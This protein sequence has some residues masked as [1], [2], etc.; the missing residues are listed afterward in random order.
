MGRKKNHPYLFLRGSRWWVRV[1][2]P[3][4]LR[5][6]YTSPHVERS[7]GTDSLKDAE[8]ER[9]LR[10][11][12]IKREFRDKLRAATGAMPSDVR[13]ALGLRDDIRKLHRSDDADDQRNLEALE[14]VVTDRAYDIAEKGGTERAK[15]FATIAL[16]TK[17]KTLQE[18]FAEWIGVEG[19]QG[20]TCAKYRR[21]F[22]EVLGHFGLPDALPSFVTAERVRGYVEYV[23]TKAVT[24]KGAPLDPATKR[25]R[26]NAMS[27]FWRWMESV[28]LAPAG[29]AAFWRGHVIAGARAKARQV[30]KERPYKDAEIIALCEGP[31][32]RPNATYSKR[33]MIEL[34]AL[35]LLTGARLEE[36]C[37]RTLGDIEAVKGAGY[38]LHIRDAKTPSGNRSLPIRHAIAVAVIKRRIGKRSDPNAYLFAELVPGGPD[39]K[40]SWQVQKSLGDY[41]RELG[42]PEGVNFHST[43]RSFATRME[44]LGVEERWAERYFGHK[45]KSLIGSIYSKPQVLDDVAKAIKYPAPIERA[46]RAALGL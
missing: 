44:E 25:A 2:V 3:A 6:F 20:G 34:T 28:D 21:A 4:K 42:L 1:K 12:Q 46:L 27:G 24:P 13:L 11:L 16:D 22:D 32:R 23:N 37:A 8:L 19:F 17:G 35:G 7:T 26:L 10:V 38:V 15:A 31:E 5:D 39:R 43:R 18:A 33:T 45:P 41:R 30:V 14:G 36:L 29:S 9:D 40:R